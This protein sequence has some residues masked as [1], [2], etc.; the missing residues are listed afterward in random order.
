MSREYL[1]GDLSKDTSDYNH[2]I[3]IGTVLYST[4]KEVIAFNKSIVDGTR[5]LNKK[6]DSIRKIEK[7]KQVRKQEER[8]KKTGI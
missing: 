2:L 8:I 4:P 3:E 7:V 1:Q 5:E 6:Y